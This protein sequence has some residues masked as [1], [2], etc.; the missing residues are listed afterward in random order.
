[1]LFRSLLILAKM[2]YEN[3]DGN[4][5]SRQVEFARGIHA[6]G[7]DLLSLINDILDLSKIESGTTPI[8]PEEVRLRELAQD[9]DMNFRHVAQSRKL[10]FSVEID[11]DL[12]AAIIAFAGFAI[13]IGLM[14]THALAGRWGL[15]KRVDGR[16]VPPDYPSDNSRSS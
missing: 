8:E 4:L 16:L 10:S 6:S 2:L 9:A 1:M 15:F 14:I 7:T 13:L 12:P 5:T 3:A 11:S